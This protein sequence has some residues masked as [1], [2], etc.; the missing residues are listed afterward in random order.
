AEPQKPQ[1]LE[2]VA[3]VVPPP[4]PQPRDLPPAGTPVRRPPAAPAEPV[5]EP[6]EPPVQT[7]ATVGAGGRSGTQAAPDA[8]TS[9]VNSS[10]GGLPGARAD[11]LSLL[12]AWLEKHKEYPRR[13]Q[14]RRQEG[15]VLL[16]F[17]MDRQGQVLEFRI[18]RS[19]GHGLL[20]KE[21]EEMIR[22]AE[23]LPPMPQEMQQARLEL[24]VPV[25][26]LLR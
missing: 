10:G 9:E 19:S 3:A 26:F 11:Y 25:Q 21:V 22:R 6:R 18:A 7:A 14:A 13:A 24:V 5:A 23:P 12:Q 16:Q 4:P 15:T 8:G 17:V 1:P 2:P 20:D